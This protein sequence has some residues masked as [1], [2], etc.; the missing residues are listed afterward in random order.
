MTS[1]RRTGRTTG[2]IQMA[3]MAAMMGRRVMFV[4][5][6]QHYGQDLCRKAAEMVQAQNS[7]PGM[8]TMEVIVTKDSIT[9][10]LYGNVHG[11]LRFQGMSAEPSN[12]N[13]GLREP[14]LY[15]FVY[16]HHVLELQEEERKRKKRLADLNMIEQLMKEHGIKDC[17]FA[18]RV[19]GKPFKVEYE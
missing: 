8:P 5:H 9:F 15:R 6:T 4:A 16:D 14:L 3:L 7:L 1:L 19:P 13:R 2:K 18:Q 10:Y 12:I 11:I 17:W